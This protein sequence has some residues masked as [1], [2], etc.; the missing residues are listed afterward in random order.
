M[1]DEGLGLDDG[2]ENAGAAEL[3]PP[4]LQVV[5]GVSG[6]GVRHERTI[7]KGGEHGLH[8]DEVSSPCRDDQSRMQQLVVELLRLEEIVRAFLSPFSN[9]SE[10]FGF[11]FV[12]DVYLKHA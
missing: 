8:A 3:E 2:G 9:G 6:R 5:W 10:I 11:L 12:W 1:L 7:V 4:P